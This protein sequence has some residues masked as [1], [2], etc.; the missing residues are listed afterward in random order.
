MLDADF[1]REI[2]SNEA[3]LV[4]SNLTQQDVENI[5][6]AQLLE[7]VYYQW[8]LSVRVILKAAS[9]P[10]FR[11]EGNLEM[12]RQCMIKSEPF[13]REKSVGL[14]IPT[15]TVEENLPKFAEWMNE[16][17]E[18]TYFA[19]LEA[20]R[21]HLRF[22]FN[23]EKRQQLKQ[24]YITLNA[25]VLQK[26]NSQRDLL[27]ASHREHEDTLGKYH[28]NERRAELRKKALKYLF[29]RETDSFFTKK[30]GVKTFRRLAFNRIALLPTS[31]QK[32][33]QLFHLIL[34][35]MNYEKGRNE[36]ISRSKLAMKAAQEEYSKFEREMKGSGWDRIKKIH[37]ETT[38]KYDKMNKERL[39]LQ[40]E[41][42]KN[43]TLISKRLDQWEQYIKDLAKEHAELMGM[44]G[45]KFQVEDTLDAIRTQLRKT[46]LTDDK[47]ADF[48]NQLS[49]CQHVAWGID[50]EQENLAIRLIILEQFIPITVE[51]LSGEIG[52]QF[53]LTMLEKLAKRQLEAISTIPKLP[54][55]L[56]IYCSCYS[57]NFDLVLQFGRLVTD[58]GKSDYSDWEQHGK[59]AKVFG[60]LSQSLIGV[61]TPIIDDIKPGEKL[62][63]TKQYSTGTLTFQL[64]VGLYFGY[65]DP[66]VFALK[67]GCCMV[68]TAS[69]CHDNDRSFSVSH[70]L[71]IKGKVAIQFVKYLEASVGATFLKVEES[72]QFTD[73]F[74]W[75][76][77][78][79]HKWARLAALYTAWC[80]VVDP[81]SLESDRFGTMTSNDKHM[82]LSAAEQIFGDNK[83]IKKTLE[84]VSELLTEQ[85]YVVYTS[86]VNA[87]TNVNAGF[88]VNVPSPWK[89]E[90]DYTKKAQPEGAA[91]MK[92]FGVSA[93]ISPIPTKKKLFTYR[94]KMIDGYERAI[95]YSKSE[96]T[97][98]AQG[99]ITVLGWEVGLE[100]EHTKNKRWALKG[101]KTFDV[102]LDFDGLF[103]GDPLGL[104]VKLGSLLGKIPTEVLYAIP[105]IMG[106]ASIGCLSAVSVKTL[107][108][109]QQDKKLNIVTGAVTAGALGSS[110]GVLAAVKPMTGQTVLG[111]VPGDKPGDTM[112]SIGSVGTNL[113]ETVGVALLGTI[114]CKALSGL[115]AKSP[116][117]LFGIPE[118]PEECQ[119]NPKANVYSNSV[120]F[121]LGLWQC[122]L[123]DSKLDFEKLPPHERPNEVMPSNIPVL[124][125]WRKYSIS[126]REFKLP[127]KC[128]TIPIPT[129]AGEFFIKIDLEVNL[130]L[131]RQFNERIEHNTFQYVQSIYS[132]LIHRK[133]QNGQ[134]PAKAVGTSIW[135]EFLRDHQ[136]NVF[137]LCLYAG[138]KDMGYTKTINNNKYGSRTYYELRIETIDEIPGAAAFLAACISMHQQCFRAQPALLQSFQWKLLSLQNV[139]A[140]MTAAGAQSETCIEAM[141][142]YLKGKDTVSRRE[143]EASWTPTDKIGVPFHFTPNPVK[144]VKRIS[145]Y[146]AARGER[147][148]HNLSAEIDQHKGTGTVRD[149]FTSIFEVMDMKK[150]VGTLDVNT[151]R[152][153]GLKGAANDQGMDQLV[154]KHGSVQAVMK[155]ISIL[156][157][158]QGDNLLQLV[159]QRIQGASQ[160]LVNAQ[161][162]FEIISNGEV[163]ITRGRRFGSKVI[164]GNVYQNKQTSKVWTH[165]VFHTESGKK[166]SR[167]AKR[168]PGLKQ[169]DAQLDK[170]HSIAWRKTNIDERIICLNEMIVM[171][172]SYLFESPQTKRK[173]SLLTL[174]EQACDEIGLFESARRVDPPDQ[175]HS[176]RA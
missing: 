89:T 131:Q 119:T 33:A 12:M 175:S 68:Y 95:E 69:M 118:K 38:A 16:Q 57:F 73:V 51:F 145:R 34:E 78:L 66:D 152:E 90:T 74:H 50:R 42:L 160:K 45:P 156:Q 92:V 141:T 120:D 61:R 3:V 115:G 53:D 65:G 147:R 85:P 59:R 101:D 62:A 117:H 148:M 17:E 64:T 18:K 108:G 94:Y 80:N 9:H 49:Y 82:L 22:L 111:L 29:N 167:L 84:I 6:N 97:F 123:V 56:N 25:E 140:L 137:L 39:I 93:S 98:K 46:N 157:A 139:D 26:I 19:V 7:D 142:T 35:I 31:G 67:A 173:E 116:I 121:P 75:A 41:L 96:Y 23:P 106:V 171:I 4:W 158:F 32:H 30:M 122:R 163:N 176:R 165:S 124:A 159:S 172:Q 79:C 151:R 91:G 105:A 169:I 76:A 48:Q 24:D 109:K 153:L 15:A 36:D 161:R 47:R 146:V 88:G 10:T 104:G 166:V 144:L 99:A 11:D 170:Y 135:K 126:G 83:R 63:M 103:S 150:E 1:I 155:Q 128:S 168:K 125:Y 149:A 162:Y 21:D 154:Q 72:Y 132:G 37:T 134:R 55:A 81:R 5:S 127:D 27:F 71:E 70:S 143:D 87:L 107:L 113:I 28:N 14:P 102:T 77:W 60:W 100:F 8:I 129:P 58:F 40:N 52:S 164:N 130:S 54:K 133:G 110:V 13:R 112:N 20:Q 136:R 86:A 44:D 174:T 138:C 43:G 114:V 2:K